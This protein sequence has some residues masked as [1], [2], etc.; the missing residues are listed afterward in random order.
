MNVDD[1]WVGFIADSVR[2]DRA[3][4]GAEPRG[5]AGGKV[6]FYG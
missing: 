2:C 1:V 4:P 5:S 3:D 6:V